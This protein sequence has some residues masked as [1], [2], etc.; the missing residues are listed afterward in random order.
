MDE[1]R[2][3]SGEDGPDDLTADIGEAMIT[4]VVAEGE[5]FVIETE[6]VEEGGVQIVHVDLA[7]HGEVPE[8]VGGAPREPGFHATPGQP[9]GEAAGIVIATGSI[10]FRV[11]RATEFSAPPYE[12][13]FEEPASMEIGEETGDGFVG[14]A[15]VLGVAWKVA[16]LIPAWV[17]GVV[18]VG[19]LDEADAGL[20]QAAGHKTLAAEFVG[21]VL[22][23]SVQGAGGVGFTGDIE[24]GGRG[25][26]HAPGEF[27]GMDDRFGGGL[28]RGESGLLVIDLLEEIELASA[29]DGIGA[30]S[31]EG[32][33]G[34]FAGGSTGDAEGGS[35]MNGGKEG[36]TPVAGA[37]IAEAGGEGDEGGQIGVF[38]AEPVADPGA[39]AGSDEGGGAA[40]EEEGGGT[41]CDA[42][43]L[44]AV[45]E[46]ELVHPLGGV[47][48]KFTDPVP[49]L[50]MTRELPGRTHH[51][52]TR[53][54]RTRVGENPG[55]IEGHLLPFMPVEQGFVIV[56][57]D[58][59]RAALHEEEDHPAHPRSDERG[60]R[61]Q[62]TAGEPGDSGEGESA[63]ATGQP[64]EGGPA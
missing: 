57:V 33:E 14:G 29:C 13:V 26:L 5:L 60:S 47:R 20:A 30:G 11:R 48:E 8:V 40:M 38:G 35:L 23:D 31:G 37:A 50:A 19:D 7:I 9:G 16:V 44:H 53:G 49:G 63:K 39:D 32:T 42:F 41:V 56:G 46:A 21:G 22:P 2:A 18:A 52:L 10:L 34:H 64:L 27:V 6:Q 58:L 54:Q 36:G 45:Q 3:P 17:G 61:G 51:A 25:G 43:G 4:S 62:G 28:V 15:G 12:G 1:G 24:Q 59:T 55:V